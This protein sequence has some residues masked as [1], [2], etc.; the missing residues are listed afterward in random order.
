MNEI[1]MQKDN[2]NVWHPYT[3]VDLDKSSEYKVNQVARMEVYG[4]AKQRSLPQ[5]RLY[6][7]LCGIVG[8]N[9]T[10]PMWNTKESVDFSLRVAL[11]FVDERYT[12]V[13]PDGTVQ[14]KYRSIAFKNLKHIEACNY[15]GRAIPLMAIRLKVTEQKL[16]EMGRNA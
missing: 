9:C 4:I 5:L 11:H 1:L 16:L 7:G 6:W 3:V 12:A 14:F 8:D 13:R 2:T 10:D 15:F